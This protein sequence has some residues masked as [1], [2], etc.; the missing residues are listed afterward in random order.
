MPYDVAVIGLGAMGSAALWQ[1]AKRGLSGVGIDRF[2]PPHP[3]GSTHGHTR[4]IREA[5]YEHPLYVPL[6]QRAYTMWD[7]LAREARTELF[8]PTGGLMLGA[9]Q[10]TLVRGAL[11]SAR[12]HHLTYELL[13]APE[14]RRRFPAL[15]LPDGQ[16]G[17]HEPRAGLL[18]PE[19]GVSTMLAAAASAGAEIRTGARVTGWHA[20]ADLV[21]VTTDLGDV[22]AARVIIAAGAWMGS[23]VP[24]LAA[25]LTPTRQMGHWFEPRAHPERFLADR[26]PVLLWEHSPERFF[27]SLPDAGDGL[28]ASIHHE[29]IPVDPDAQRRDVTAAETAALCAIMERLMPDGVGRV[30]ERGTCLYTNTPDGHFA[31]GIHPGAPRVIIASPCSGHGFKFAPAIGEL[32]AGLVLGEAPRFDLEP[33]RIGRLWE[34]KTPHTT[35]PAA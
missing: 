6:V 7:E 22:T 1:L 10:G 30:I 34:R 24:E 8:R 13:D 9:E 5:Y 20:T 21:T 32:L 2:V 31:I 15:T 28:K 26:L 29:G 35:P 25:S 12:D 33:F 11:R 27:Y 18:F 16:V 17:V 4:I 19:K 23:L 3:H 14:V